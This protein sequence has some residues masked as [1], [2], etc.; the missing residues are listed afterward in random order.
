MVG[1]G[2]RAFFAPFDAASAATTNNKAIGP[3]IVDLSQG[4]FDSGQTMNGLTGFVDLGWIRDFAIT[5][6]TKVG[7]IRAGFRGAVSV[8]IR[9]QIGESFEFKFREYG[10][11]QMKCATGANVFNL[12]PGTA[13]STLGP[14]SATGGV[15]TA[16]TAYTP[17]DNTAGIGGNAT[18]TVPSVTGFAVGN[19]I[20]CDIDYNPA[21][22][23]LVGDAMSPV[24]PNAVLDVDYIRKNS[25]YVARVKAISGT[26]LVL[27]QPF[28]GGGGFGNVS[29]QAGA[30]IQKIVGFAARDGGSFISE[31][32]GMFL[33]DTQDGAQIAVYY[34]H[35]SIL[36]PRNLNNNFAIEN[37]GT[38]DMTGYEID[39]QYAALAFDDP[40]DGETA[41]GYKA[42]ILRPNAVPGY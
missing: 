41:V 16:M 39:A 15:A 31:W 33:L 20:V 5:T 7:Q 21:T 35:V 17:V 40:L 42:L 19:Y 18:L 38:T 25:D 29:P 24:F 37:I 13:P 6:D 34:P 8:Q 26:K 12:I 14:L 11:L 1:A 10:R 2:W 36:A 32:T 23:G 27:D 3:R 4:P 30:K 9:G 28:M 22:Y